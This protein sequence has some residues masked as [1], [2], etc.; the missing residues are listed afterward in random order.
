MKKWLNSASHA[1][2]GIIVFFR[3]ERNARIEGV[4]AMLALCLGIWLQISSAEW[5][6]ILLCIGGVLS[7]EAFNSAIERLSDL[8][9]RERHPE[10]GILKDI[11]AGA[12]FIMALLSFCIGMLIFGPPLYKML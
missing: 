4:A 1:L 5:C 10:I 7:A 9:T 11:A 12:V 2:N 3:T 6:I 8:Y